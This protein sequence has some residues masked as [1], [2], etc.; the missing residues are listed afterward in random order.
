MKTPTSDAKHRYTADA[1][2]FLALAPL[3]TSILAGVR[4]FEDDE[5]GEAEARAFA[6]KRGVGCRRVW[7]SPTRPEA[8]FEEILVVPPPPKRVPKKYRGIFAVK[9]KWPRASARI[10]AADLI[11]RLGPA[12]ERIEIAGSVRRK[13]PLVGDVELLIIP[14]CRIFVPETDA[15]IEAMLDDGILAPRL[16]EDGRI[17]GNAAENKL[18]VH[19]ETGMKVDLFFTDES[20]WY[21]MLVNRTG[22]T[23]SNIRIA[24]A[25]KAKDWK[26]NPYGVGFTLPN[27]KTI[28]AESERHV[29]DLCNLPYL[30]PEERT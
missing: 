12:T 26:W 13:K 27:G 8:A 14:R 19:R 10:V 9:Q 15:V 17:A 7:L 25:A 23:A 3:K 1:L 4:K 11:E 2:A 29:F 22:G 28:R 21:N 16:A 20:R 24:S 5:E 30:S 6:Q 18:M